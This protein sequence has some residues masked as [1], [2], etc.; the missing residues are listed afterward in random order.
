MFHRNVIVECDRTP[1]AVHVRTVSEEQGFYDLVLR[2]VRV[3]THKI[4]DRFL[5]LCLILGQTLLGREWRKFHRQRAPAAFLA[6]SLRSSAVNFSARAFAPACP[7]RTLPDGSFSGSLLS[8]T[9]NRAT[10]IAHP[11]TSAGLR[12]PFGPRGIFPSSFRVHSIIR[13]IALRLIMEC[14][15]QPRTRYGLL[16]RRKAIDFAPEELP[17]VLSVTRHPVRINLHG[18]R[19]FQRLRRG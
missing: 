1:M 3:Q 8:P 16:P 11:M 10:V 2:Y 14:V 13:R 17:F 12:S 6:I 15:I 9:D 7:L 4:Q 19:Q 18:P 5:Y